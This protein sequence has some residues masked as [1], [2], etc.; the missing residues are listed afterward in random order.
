MLARAPLAVQATSVASEQIFS[1]AGELSVP[2]R[3]RIGK[4][5]IECLMF[6]YCNS[7]RHD[8]E[9]VTAKHVKQIR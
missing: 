8:I 6:L 4:D 2:K 7:N 1:S 5:L 3:N 9:Q